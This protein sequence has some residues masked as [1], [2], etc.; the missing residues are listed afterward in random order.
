MVHE[1]NAKKYMCWAET[2]ILIVN[3]FIMGFI[4]N[5]Q[6]MLKCSFLTIYLNN[7]SCKSLS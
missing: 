2:Q 6:E 5:Q 3:G 7:K 1:Q 4:V